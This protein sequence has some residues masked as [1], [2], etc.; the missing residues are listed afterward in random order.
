MRHAVSLVCLRLPP[1]LVVPC[2]FTRAETED[3]SNH[4]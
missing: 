2:Q 1:A 4:K 3:S